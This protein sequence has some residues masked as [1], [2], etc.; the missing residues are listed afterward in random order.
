MA[1]TNASDTEPYDLPTPS[2]R[3]VSSSSNVVTLSPGFDNSIDT[4]LTTPSHINLQT[5]FLGVEHPYH[6]NYTSLKSPEAKIP[7]VACIYTPMVHYPNRGLISALL[8][9]VKSY[10]SHKLKRQIFQDAKVDKK[11]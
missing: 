1:N 9:P 2:N 7:T 6:D 3:H 11:K 5:D 10:P 4:Q 8:P